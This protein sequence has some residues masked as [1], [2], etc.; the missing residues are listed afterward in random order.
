M[1]STSDGFGRAAGRA[2]SRPLKV[3]HVSVGWSDLKEVQ[4][5]FAAA[6]MA[7]EYGGPHS[8]GRTH[9]SLLGFGD[10][11]YIELISGL[12]SGVEPD[13]WSRQIEGD[14]GP[15]AWCVGSEDIAAEVARARSLGIPAT[16]PDDYTRRRPDG[17]LVKWQLGFLGDGEPGS[18]LPFL[19]RDETPRDLRAR[20]SPSVSATGAHLLGITTVVLA[21]KDL[22][23]SIALFRGFY[24]WGEPETR[25]DLIRGAILARFEGSPVV[26]AEPRG[27][28]WPGERLS[29]YGP[30]PCAF[31]IGTDDLDAAGVRH[32]LGGPE[33]WFDGDRV[34]WVRPLKEMGIPLGVY[35][36]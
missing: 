22:P 28:G 30:S 18:V 15:C 24:G 31:L 17:V 16:G 13:I 21:V 8:S 6:G 36:R 19:I 9:M 32:P 29:A 7:T 4:D 20:P 23:E 34:R 33:E 11:S 35:G 5:A 25:R 12:K 3:D 2:A 27:E 14:G 26:L 10:G 1:R